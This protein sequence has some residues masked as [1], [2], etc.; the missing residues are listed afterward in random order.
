ME[1]SL[2]IYPLG[3]GGT[4][5]PEAPGSGSCPCGQPHAKITDRVFTPPKVVFKGLGEMSLNQMHGGCSG[6][7][8]VRGGGP[9]GRRSTLLR[10]LGG[11]F[12]LLV[13]CA[14]SFPMSLFLQLNDLPANVTHM[15]EHICQ[16]HSI[17]SSTAYI[18][19][20]VLQQTA[21]QG[22]TSPH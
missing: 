21:V 15:L 6:G 19:D 5:H 22:R 2:S 12:V 20:L 14:R 9:N 13:P 18:S 16:Y 3:R 8:G 17:N 4:A 11:V 10:L 1:R 7:H